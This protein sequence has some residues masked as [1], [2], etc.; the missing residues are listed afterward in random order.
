MN[1]TLKITIGTAAA[2]LIL[3]TIFALFSFFVLRQALPEYSGEISVRGINNNVTIYRD[4]LAVPYIQARNESDAYFALGYLHAQERMFQMDLLRRAGTGTLSE[5]FGS[6]TAAFDKMFKTL[7]IYRR[8]KTDYPKLSETTKNLLESYSAG[9]NAYLKDNR[10]NASIEFDVIGYQP[11][12]WE[13]EHSLVIAKLVAWE[14]NKSWWV[15][16]AMTHLIQKF[17]AEKVKE[18]IP[19]YPENAPLIIPDD[20]NKFSTVS[21][22]LINTDRKFRKLLGFNGT[23]IG[24][25]NWA[26]NA[27]ASASGKPIIANDPHLAFQAPGRWYIANLRCPEL[28]VSGFTLPGMPGIVIGK[29]DNV[30][31]ALTNVM[32][33]D[34]DFYNERLDSAKTKYFLD[35]QWQNLKIYTDTV[36]VKDS[37]DIIFEI[38]ETH[39]GPII[40]DVHNFNSL[41]PNQYQKD[42]VLSIRWTALDFSDEFLGMNKINKAK[43]WEEFKEG[44]EDFTV[45]GQNFVYA[46]KDGNIGYICGAKLPKRKSSSPTLVYDGTN[47]DN[48]WKGFVPFNEMPMLYNPDRNFIA[49]ANN[50]TVS[51]FKY[52]ISNLWEPPSR[53]LRINE[54]L[55]S[56]PKH[57]VEDFKNYQN[58]FQSKYASEIVPY[59]LA[60]FEG[61]KINDRNLNLSLELLRTWNFKMDMNSQTPS[62][63]AYFYQHLLKNIFLD[64]MGEELFNEYVFIANVPY[65]IIQQLFAAG[66]SIWFDNINT[67]DVESKNDII[68]KSL[69]DALAELEKSFGEN[70][71]DWQ[72]KKIHTIT[73]RHFFSG[74]SSILDKIVNVGPFEIS[75]D[76]TTI[77]NTEYSFTKPFKVELG[78]SMRFIYDFAEPDILEFVLSNGQSGHIFS[79]HYSDMTHMWLNGKY[80]KINTD[81]SI[82]AEKSDLILILNPE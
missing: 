77:C 12:D 62:I 32:A 76:G 60:A 31:W 45:P 53:I 48:D 39:R 67:D 34:T 33:D 42:A 40:S 4:S 52:H 19:D 65:R 7:G 5:V 25:N 36:A 15:D 37:A 81:F 21:V 28:N 11:K 49:S 18:I 22:D 51:D 47:S 14:L 9:I 8:L 10:N 66:S 74:Q 16:I 75:G 57:S 56:K 43:N 38:K 26:V 64:E 20:I 54:L 3:V 46:D 24:S 70:L 82:I 72:W 17:G 78:P 44:V 13:P 58:D 30:A 29:N 35:N 69:D 73:F 23:H 63:Y 1:R 79:E 50:K 61:L 55:Q 71:E 80:A 2:L 27:N 41:Y 68:R 6:R 59:I